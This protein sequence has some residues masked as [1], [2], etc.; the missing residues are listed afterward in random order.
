MNDSLMKLKNIHK[1]IYFISCFV[2]A[3][4]NFQ[5]FLYFHE[6]KA[7]RHHFL[8]K[9]NLWAIYLKLSFEKFQ[10][11]HSHPTKIWKET[12]WIRHILS[13]DLNFTAKLQ[14]R[15]IKV[16][17]WKFKLFLEILPC[18]NSIFLFNFTWQTIFFT[19]SCWRMTLRKH[20]VAK[21]WFSIFFI[22][23]LSNHI[24]FFCSAQTKIGSMAIT[25]HHL[26]YRI[27]ECKKQI[28]NKPSKY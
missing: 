14:E 7:L 24:K 16:K 8:S 4:K 27:T 22:W 17:F 26:Q 18:Q 23:A 15:E 6:W 2:Q 1:K 3:L 10:T 12:V 21:F 11:Q 13:S 25:Q 19:L 5:F 28:M 9:S 20:L